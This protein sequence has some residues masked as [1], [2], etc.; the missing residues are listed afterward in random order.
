MILAIGILAIGFIIGYTVR[1]LRTGFRTEDGRWI[2]RNY[3]APNKRIPD[4]VSGPSTMS[5]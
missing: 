5:F 2:T 3:R 4:S 1:D